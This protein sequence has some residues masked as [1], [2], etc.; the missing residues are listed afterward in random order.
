[1]DPNLFEKALY[2]IG[3][4]LILSVI[5]IIII[6]VAT[7]KPIPDILQLI[8]SSSLTGLIGMLV[9]RKD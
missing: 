2:F 3:T 6:V 4:V 7:D 9:Q 1:M 8:A 5:G